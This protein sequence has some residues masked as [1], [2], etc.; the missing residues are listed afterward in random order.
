MALLCCCFLFS[1]PCPCSSLYP[2]LSA[3]QFNYSQFVCLYLIDII[4]KVQFIHFILLYTKSSLTILCLQKNLITSHTLKKK[5]Q[6]ISAFRI[7]DCILLH[8]ELISFCAH[9][10]NKIM[11]HANAL[12]NR[13]LA[14]TNEKR[15]RKSID[16][17]A[18]T[19][20]I[21]LHNCVVA[22]ANDPGFR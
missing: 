6:T 4:L 12:D 1:S 13:L 7:V 18:T 9:T 11:P 21:A 8:C 19:W 3:T 5:K 17:F 22:S 15:L 14:T 10:H 2:P 16:I 20:N